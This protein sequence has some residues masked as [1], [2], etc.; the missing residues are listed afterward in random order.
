MRNITKL[1]CW[2]ALENLGFKRA[3]FNKKGHVGAYIMIQGEEF[4]IEPKYYLHR[5]YH[6]VH[7]GQKIDCNKLVEAR[8]ILPLIHEILESIN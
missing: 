1:P 6:V 8:E 3:Q 2:P 4:V 5:I 7:Y